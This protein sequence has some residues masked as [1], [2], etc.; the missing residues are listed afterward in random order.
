[1]WCKSNLKITLELKWSTNF[2]NFWK[3]NLN[4]NKVKHLTCIDQSS[5]GKSY[6][7]K[8][9]KKTLRKMEKRVSMEHQ[10]PWLWGVAK[11]K[12][13]V[14][15]KFWKENLS[16]NFVLYIYHFRYISILFHLYIWNTHNILQ[17]KLY[18]H[19]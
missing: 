4:L 7:E 3:K 2:D 19:T 6:D 9:F 1:M 14:D 18:L 10:S 15:K 13:K 17:I 11:R 12:H 5:K 16:L 8:S